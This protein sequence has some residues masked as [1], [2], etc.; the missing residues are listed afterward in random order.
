MSDESKCAHCGKAPGALYENPKS[1]QSAVGSQQSEKKEFLCFDCLDKIAPKYVDK[2]PG[3]RERERK[4]GVG[5]RE[6][7][8][9]KTTPTSY[10]LFPTSEVGPSAPLPAARSKPERESKQPSRSPALPLS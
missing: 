6:S 9:A 5:S 10:F 8:V 3:W 2:Y 7:G 4:R 1:R